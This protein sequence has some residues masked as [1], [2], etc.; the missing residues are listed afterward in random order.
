MPTHLQRQTHQN[1][2][3]TLISNLKAKKAQ[4]DTFQTLKIYNSQSKLPA[5]QS[6]NMKGSVY[7]LRG[8]PEGQKTTTLS[9][10]SPIL[11]N[12]TQGFSCTVLNTAG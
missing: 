6:L 7:E 9:V 10:D 12:L 2:I 1:N 3:L 5:K 4:N 11:P 8:T